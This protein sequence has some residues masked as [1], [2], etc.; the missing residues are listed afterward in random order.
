[1]IMNTDEVSSGTCKGSLGPLVTDTFPKDPFVKAQCMFEFSRCIPT[2]APNS[3]KQNI[4]QFTLPWLSAIAERPFI[5]YF[6]LALDSFYW[7]SCMTGW[8][9]SSRF[10]K[11]ILCAILMV[12]WQRLCGPYPKS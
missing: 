5:L 2:R 8:V 11:C 10:Q 3:Y 7:H 6:F 12:T 4:S 9:F 1:M